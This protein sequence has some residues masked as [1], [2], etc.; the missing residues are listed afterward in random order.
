MEN[1]FTTESSFGFDM[2]TPGKCLVL[3]RLIFDLILQIIFLN[4]DLHFLYIYY[5]MI[6][7]CASC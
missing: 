1:D 2:T 3:A 6:A 4:G 7:V 5:D